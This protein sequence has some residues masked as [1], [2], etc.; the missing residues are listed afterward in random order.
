MTKVFIAGFQHE[1]NTFAPSLADWA[2]FNRGDAFPAYI[3][4]QAMQ[5]Q[6]TGVNIPVGGFIDAAKRHGWQLWPS[7]WAGASP[8]SFV[9]E[10]AFE[11]T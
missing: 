11:R 8:S 4:G 5:D 2:A 9:T 7:V 3:R 10:D 6:F 1:T